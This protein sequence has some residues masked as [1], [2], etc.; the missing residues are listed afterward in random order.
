MSTVAITAPSTACPASRPPAWTRPV[1]FLLLAVA[2]ALR[3]FPAWPLIVPAEG[4]PPR[5][6]DNDALF[7]LRHATHV[8]ENFPELQRWEDVSRYPELERNDASG[9]WDLSLGAAGRALAAV[10]GLAPADATAWAAFFAPP[11]LL[12]LTFLLAYRLWRRLGDASV[13]LVAAA[14]LVLLPGDTFTRTAAGYCDHHVVEMF[15]VVWTAL[16]WIR[17]VTAEIQRARAWWHPAWG[18]AAPLTVLHFSWLGAPLH[19]LV[20]VVAAV[21]TTLLAPGA[22]SD[23]R[24]CARAAVRLLLAHGLMCGIAGLIFPVAVLRESLHAGMLAGSAAAIAGLGGLGA[25]LGR[26]QDRWPAAG[27]RISGFAFAA[28][29]VLIAV[30]W[31]TVPLVRAA[32]QFGLS[33]KAATVFEH[34]A[35]TWRLFFGLTGA[36]GALALVSPVILVMTGAWRSSAALGAVMLPLLH[37]ALWARTGDYI[38]QV[39]LQA[40]LAAGTAATLTHRWRPRAGWSL[41]I[42]VSLAVLWG[43]GPARWTFPLVIDQRNVTEAVRVQHEGWTQTVAWWRTVP[44]PSPLAVDAAP[45]QNAAF[46]P[47][48]QVGVLGDWA[49]GNIVNTYTGWPVV[50]SR[51]PDAEGL[52]PLFATSDEEALRLPLRGR[53]VGDSVRWVAI[54][55]R[56]FGDYFFAHLSTLD[57]PREPFLT[58]IRLNT[59]DGERDTVALGSEYERLLGRRLLAADG[60]GLAHFR[61]VYESP[62]QVALRHLLLTAAET[63]SLQSDRVPADALDTARATLARTSWQEGARLGYRGELHP[64]VKIFEIVRGATLHGR[65]DPETIVHLRLHATVRSTGRDLTLVWSTPAAADGTWQITVPYAT[66]SLPDWNAVSPAPAGYLVEFKSTEARLRLSPPPLRRM[67]VPEAAIRSGERLDVDAQR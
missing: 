41:V 36:A 44:A 50:N 15:A 6:V 46:S 53:T 16:A 33:E 20:L 45:G 56:T 21:V 52:R 23:P 32:V 67:R 9:L 49:S 26:A 31:A 24:A 47:R 13:A 42:A 65:T 28:C 57:R 61:L 38:Y 1:L 62:R 40:V 63:W 2:L 66:E 34:P 35:V 7:H 22:G 58:R 29:F 12:T 60:A 27:A 8:A 5:P 39:A 25:V 11:L 54:E 17:L 48:G 59:A 30:A 19:L 55:P 64:S 37:V 14:W 18:A 10:T 3:I 4:G 51:Y 43:V